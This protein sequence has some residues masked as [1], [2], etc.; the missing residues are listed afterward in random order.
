MYISKKDNMRKRHLFIVSFILLSGIAYLFYTNGKR[1]TP[2]IAPVGQLAIP[3]SSWLYGTFNLD[4]I[5]KDIA[6]SSL[7]NG[8]ISKLFQA[9]TNSN[10]LLKIFKSPTDYSITDQDN[11]R[12]FSIWKNHIMYKG[13]L[14]NVEN[15][16]QLQETFK[17]DS[18]RLQK[19]SAFSFRT[20]EGYW[21]YNNQNLLFIAQQLQ[22]SL[23]AQNIFN[24]RT[25]STQLVANDSLYLSCTINTQF[26][27]D[28]I[29]HPLIDSS[30]IQIAVKANTDYIDID[31][32]Y[33]G[34]AI[35]YFNPVAI[36][37]PSEDAGLYAA[38]SLTRAGLDELLNAYA[39][40][41]SGSHKLPIDLHAFINILQN[42]T[43]TVEFNGWDKLLQSFY[44]YELNDEFET[45][46]VKKDSL[47]LE[48]TFRISLAN[49][50]SK[51]ITDFFNYLHQSGL[52][53]KNKKP[54]FKTTLGNFDSELMISKDSSLV[55][56]NSHPPAEMRSDKV[57]NCIFY[58]SCKPYNIKGLF[59]QKELKERKKTASVAEFNIDA[60]KKS[61]TFNGHVKVLFK[62]D[63]HP[64]LSMVDL[65][66]K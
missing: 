19:T 21:L 12:Y 25:Q 55:F 39:A 34:A 27:L 16:K 18:L 2:V 53:S 7:L 20:S 9:D 31:W 35:N 41:T 42:N 44:R 43:L 37:E 61:N 65:L 10:T 40:T 59:D 60:Y 8:D 46:M 63:K 38:C 56:Q 6:L 58:L 64:L 47:Y 32:N 3:D 17:S 1:D 66:K 30:S 29:R 33:K 49:A 13:L 51:E 14:F 5:S 11:I 36:H 4:K 26:Y 24:Q 15:N 45:V 23:V 48:P 57:N 52:I 22:D 54:P 62:E 50:D 28:S